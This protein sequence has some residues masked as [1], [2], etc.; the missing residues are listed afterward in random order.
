MSLTSGPIH[1]E[2]M[3][4]GVKQRQRGEVPLARLD[5][6][7]L[8][9][10]DAGKDERNWRKDHAFRQPGSAAGVEDDRGVLRRGYGQC[11]AMRRLDQVREGPIV[12]LRVRA[13]H[14]GSQATALLRSKD[15]EL[16][17][18][19]GV[20]DEHVRAAILQRVPEIV[21]DQPSV[22]R[23]PYGAHANGGEHDEQLLAAR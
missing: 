22:H 11:V 2:L 23:R 16:C 15:V 12:A 8:A 13:D 19:L 7:S 14:I 6:E 18:V 3:G 17:V 4:R 5:G 9:V 1:G 21:A 20:D 10:A